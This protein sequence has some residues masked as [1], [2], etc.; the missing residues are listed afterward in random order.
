MQA[1]Q[2]YTRTAPT[3]GPLHDR[4]LHPQIAAEQGH[5]QAQRQ[6]ASLRR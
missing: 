5:A 6:Y 4:E 1:L 2:A 3:T